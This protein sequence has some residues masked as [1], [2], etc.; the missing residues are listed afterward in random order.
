MKILWSNDLWSDF[1]EHKQLLFSF[2][3]HNLRSW[4]NIIG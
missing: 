3:W 2:S 1:E 4:K